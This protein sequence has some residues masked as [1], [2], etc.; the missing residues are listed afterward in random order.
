MRFVK[1]HAQGD[2]SE[3][4]LFSSLDNYRRALAQACKAA[5]VEHASTHDLRHAAGQ[6]LI[7]VGVPVELVSR[8]LGHATT[9][10]T[11]TVYARVRRDA[12][13]DRM[14]DA[15]DPGYA[16]V[17]SKARSKRD[18]VV[19]TIR[20]IPSPKMPVLYAVKSVEKTPAHWLST[21]AISCDAPAA[22]DSVI[23]I[24]HESASSRG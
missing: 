11:E 4:G 15:I 12:L 17:A 21:A 24:P 7:D 10:I 14:L 6:W 18:R 20:A 9:S 19:E 1:R 8:I 2:G 3:G 13:S 22:P 16:T 5:N 23:S